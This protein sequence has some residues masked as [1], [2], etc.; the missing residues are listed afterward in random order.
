ML[1]L[2]RAVGPL[3]EDWLARHLPDRKDKVL[4]RIRAVRGGQLNDSRFGSRMAGEGFFAEQTAALF[5]V[6]QRKCGLDGPGPA[7]SAAHFR[8]PGGDQL[9][10]FE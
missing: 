5:A 9:A 3:F 4:N 8:R 6:A 1:R 7:L 2:P 10:L